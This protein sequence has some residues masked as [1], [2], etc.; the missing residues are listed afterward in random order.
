MDKWGKNK[1]NL[2]PTS[3]RQEILFGIGE[4]IDNNMVKFPCG[5]VGAK[6]A[7]V[8]QEAIDARYNE[9]L[10]RKIIQM[11]VE[12]KMIF[13]GHILIHRFSDVQELWPEYSLE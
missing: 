1:W 10:F 7:I 13:C 2:I 12:E 6:F 4:I 9:T 8:M 5:T 3:R 11:M